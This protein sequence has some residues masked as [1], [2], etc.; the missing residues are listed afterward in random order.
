MTRTT[1]FMLL[2]LIFANHLRGQI[3]EYGVPPLTNYPPEITGG[4][5]QNWAVVEDN[6]G[7]VYIG[8]DEKGVI[9]YDGSEWRTIPVANN[10]T[11]RSLACAADGTV[12]VGA[13]SEIGRLVPD[14]G[15]NLQYESLIPLIDS[16]IRLFDV[17][18]TYCVEEKV[19]FHTQKYILIYYPE[20]DS[21]ALQRNE[22]H[23]L[24][25]FHENS[26]NGFPL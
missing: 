17:W 1:I 23:V 25:G 24:F 3:N 10:S 18:K 14:A 6:R 4:S 16:S 20:K 5:E 26:K 12:Y 2:L 9:E 15:G 22:R 8:N 19:Y 13:V 11:V 7:I 21:I